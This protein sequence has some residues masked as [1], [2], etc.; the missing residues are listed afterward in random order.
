MRI[1]VITRTMAEFANIQGKF[2][3]ISK[4]G[5]ELTV[6]S[7]ARWAGSDREFRG[8]EPDGFELIVHECRFSGTTSVRLGNHLHFYP[9]ISRV[10][11]SRKWDLVHIDE[12]P[13]NFATYLAMRACLR[14]GVPAVF[15]TWQNL[16]K[17]YPPPFNFFER[18]V[19]ANAAGGM[20]GNSEG[21]AVLRR[22]GFSKP[23]AHIPHL[24]VDAAWFRRRDASGLRRKLGLDGVFAVG[25]V[26]RFSPEKGLDTLI[27]ALA[28][29]PGDCVLVLLGTGGERPRLQA[30]AQRLGASGRIRWV[31]WVN[32]AEVADYMSALDVLTLPSRTR[33]NI[34]EQ[35]GRVL[36]EAM[37]SEICVVGS[38]SGEI[39]RVIGD[40]GLVFHEGDERELAGHLRRL[41]Q[42]TALRE[43]L[44]SRGRERALNHFTYAQIASQAVEFYRRVCS[45][46]NETEQEAPESL[47]VGAGVGRTLV[48]G[49]TR[50]P[51]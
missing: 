46:D 13:F 45:G 8:V 32:S 21:L 5:V 23:A 41:M 10:I 48:Q 2:R 14:Q 44:A 43:L 38:D 31:P 33:W 4:L 22:R 17:S 24:G 3:E 35:F 15:T 28:L 9:G 25:F 47:Q 49:G 34:K 12:E 29:L 36:V 18:Y 19:L 26:G 37:A 7:P 50:A 16:M 6:V 39:P 40:A 11:R 30:M 51:R 27:K 20:A 42:D 1:L